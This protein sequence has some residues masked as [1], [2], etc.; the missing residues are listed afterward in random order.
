MDTN[1]SNKDTLIRDNKRIGSSKRYRQVNKSKGNFKGDV[2]KMNGHVFQTHTETK[3]TGQ[4]NKSLEILK[5]LAATKNKKDIKYFNTLF[6]NLIKLFIPILILPVA[7]VVKN[8]DGEVMSNKGKNVEM[9]NNQIEVDFHN[10]Q[11]KSYVEKEEILESTLTSF[12]NVT[13]VQCS[14][15]TKKLKDQHVFKTIEKKTHV[16]GLLKEIKS[17]IKVVESMNIFDSIDEIQRRFF[18][19]RKTDED[20]NIANLQKFK[21]LIE[22]REHIG[23]DMFK[24]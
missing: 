8:Q 13:W 12:Y 2:A 9:E 19:Y 15:L 22:V 21:N 6:R 16:V 18:L 11:V 1:D 7:E 5:I 17:I 10:D 14:K 24:D 23:I 4:F 3:K 20:D